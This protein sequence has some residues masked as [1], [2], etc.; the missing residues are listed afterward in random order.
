MSTQHQMDD[1][2]IANLPAW[3]TTGIVAII[4]SLTSA[5][6][7]LFRRSLTERE[8]EMEA[9]QKSHTE[10][11]T[12]LKKDRDDLK[13]ESVKCREDREELRVRIKELEVR[14]EFMERK[15]DNG[16]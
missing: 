5:V 8:R 12:E 6:A 10:E 2:A 14:S 7:F 1:Q 4:A 15:I 11:L 3:I 16:K 13:I 9:V